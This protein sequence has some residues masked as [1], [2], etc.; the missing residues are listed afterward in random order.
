MIRDIN[1]V[2]SCVIIIFVFHKGLC[3]HGRVTFSESLTSTTG[4]SVL[5]INKPTPMSTY[6]ITASSAVNKTNK[7]T[8]GSSKSQWHVQTSTSFH[9][10]VHT[11]ELSSNNITKTIKEI[12][13]NSVTGTIF[14]PILSSM[15]STISSSS[16]QIDNVASTQ[17]LIINSNKILNENSSNKNTEIIRSTII[18]HTDNGRSDSQVQSTKNTRTHVPSLRIHTSTSSRYYATPSQQTKYI[19]SKQSTSS[20]KQTLSGLSTIHATKLAIKTSS[21]FATSA[22]A[23]IKTSTLSYITPS[24]PSYNTPLRRPPHRTSVVTNREYKI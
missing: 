14:S 4:I 8:R 16:V 22:S 5:S 10:N 1:F 17:Y 24:M 9:Q 2:Y 20:D 7:N 19:N 3:S 6:N 21:R 13:N 11:Y 23:H 15:H 18:M 12:D